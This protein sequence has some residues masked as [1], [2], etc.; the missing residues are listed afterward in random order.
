MN[1]KEEIRVK[2][3]E[4]LAK[5]KEIIKQG[6]VQR[7]IVKDDK[8]AKYLEIPVTLGVVGVVIAPYL[9]AIAALAVLATELTIEIIR[10]ED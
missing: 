10:K 6:N 7:I 2:A 3:D 9:A 1:L 8:G 4:L 5:I